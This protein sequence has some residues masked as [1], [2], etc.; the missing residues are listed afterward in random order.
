MNFGYI[1]RSIQQSPQFIEAVKE[2]EGGSRRVNMSGLSGS[3]SAF[4]AAALAGKGFPVVMVCNSGA[5]AR[6]VLEDLRSIA[7]RVYYYPPLQPIL[8][9]DMVHSME[10]EWRG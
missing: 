7:G 8:Y 6:E 2:L 5:R 3:R 10:A 9:N 1:V 4:W